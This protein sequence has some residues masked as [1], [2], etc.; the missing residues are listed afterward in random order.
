MPYAIRLV[1]EAERLSDELF[2]IAVLSLE[3]PHFGNFTKVV[4]TLEDSI[5]RCERRQRKLES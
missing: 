1:D 3:S 5:R 2:A 4:N